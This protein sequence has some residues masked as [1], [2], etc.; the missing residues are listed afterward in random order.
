MLLTCHIFITG[1][2]WLDSRLQTR[3]PYP[4]S[5]DHEEAV[6]YCLLNSF[7]RQCVGRG[8]LGSNGLLTISQECPTGRSTAEDISTLRAKEP[9]CGI[10]DIHGPKQAVAGK[11]EGHWLHLGLGG[12]GEDWS[13]V[14]Q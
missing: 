12:L 7:S 10:Y 4:S 6:R 8:H 14:R 5:S 3:K 9:D 1:A 13:R 11:P 2:I